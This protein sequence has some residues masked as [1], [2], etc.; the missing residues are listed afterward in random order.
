MP[1]KPQHPSRR[2]LVYSQPVK[3]EVELWVEPRI[4][5]VS[6]L[7]SFITHSLLTFLVG[8]GQEAESSWKHA[9]SSRFGL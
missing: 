2:D 5:I 3:E 6:Q 1:L 9:P 8:K 7:M 4:T